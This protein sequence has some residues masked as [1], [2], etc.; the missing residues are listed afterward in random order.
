MTL[1]QL[2]ND[3]TN[4]A[5]TLYNSCVNRDKGHSLFKGGR[6]NAGI[7]KGKLG[8][9]LQK[10]ITTEEATFYA[11]F[12]PVDLPQETN[13]DQPWPWQQRTQSNSRKKTKDWIQILL[14]LDDHATIFVDVIPAMGTWICDIFNYIPR[15]VWS[16]ATQLIARLYRS[17]KQLF[18][19]TYGN[20]QLS[21]EELEEIR[22]QFFFAKIDTSLEDLFDFSIKIRSGTKKT[23]RQIFCHIEESLAHAQYGKH[24]HVHRHSLYLLFHIA[25]LD[26]DWQGK[27]FDAST[28]TYQKHILKI[29]DPSCESVLYTALLEV[30]Y[31]DGH[32]SSL[33]WSTIQGLQNTVPIPAFPML[34]STTPFANWLPES[35]NIIRKKVLNIRALKTNTQLV[36]RFHVTNGMF[37]KAKTNSRT[38]QLYH[39]IQDWMASHQTKAEW[40]EFTYDY[41]AKWLQTFNDPAKSSILQN[42]VKTIEA[43]SPVEQRKKLIENYTLFIGQDDYAIQTNE[44]RKVAFFELW[45][46]LSMPNMFEGSFGTHLIETRIPLIFDRVEGLNQSMLEFV[47]A[48]FHKEVGK[49]E[50]SRL[51]LLLA[52]LVQEQKLGSNDH[53]LSQLIRDGIFGRLFVLE[54]K[55]DDS[56][57]SVAGIT[58]H[59][60]SP[61]AVW[62]MKTSHFKAYRTPLLY[63]II[64]SFL[65]DCHSEAQKFYLFW[66]LSIYEP[67][68]EIYELFAKNLQFPF[69]LLHDTPVKY[70]NIDWVEKCALLQNLS[71][72]QAQ[73]DHDL[74]PNKNKRSVAPIDILQQYGAIWQPFIDNNRSVFLLKNE[75]A[76]NERVWNEM[77]SFWEK[78]TQTDVFDT[79]LQLKDWQEQHGCFTSFLRN[80]QQFLAT[81]FHDASNEPIQSVIQQIDTIC[82]DLER[83]NISDFEEGLRI[84]CEKDPHYLKHRVPF[85][86]NFMYA[87]TVSKLQIVLKKIVHTETKYLKWDEEIVS[88][89]I[90]FDKMAS[91]FAN[92]DGYWNHT[93]QVFENSSIEDLIAK[94]WIDN[95]GY[96]DAWSNNEYLVGLQE[97]EH[98]FEYYPFGLFRAYLSLIEQVVQNPNIL[99]KQYYSLCMAILKRLEDPEIQSKTTELVTFDN[100]KFLTQIDSYCKNFRK[101]GLFTI[102]V[103][104]SESHEST[105]FGDKIRRFGQYHCF[106]PFVASV[107]SLTCLLDFGDS[108]LHLYD[109]NHVA[110]ISSVVLSLTTAFL[111]PYFSKHQDVGLP[112]AQSFL[113]SAPTFVASASFSSMVTLIWTLSAEGPV[114]GI[115]P[116]LLML[117]FTTIIKAAADGAFD[118]DT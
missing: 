38:A 32:Q 82:D 6:F 20:S 64:Q 41:L 80:F 13:K 21:I 81:I 105:K 52:I 25:L 15:D 79:Y 97:Y 72:N 11:A 116:F 44:E 9:V 37:P 31:F 110:G 90:K 30:C 91:Y 1:Q 49:A 17:S 5:Q 3:S 10:N 84:I 65:M 14:D 47:K 53:D 8:G 70:T 75:P 101:Q 59:S 85:A 19:T 56:I 96:S 12:L 89:N 46:L 109:Y 48:Q 51:V 24:S 61:I 76:W 34:T 63:Q 67:D 2:Q 117:F 26:A 112:I 33:N 40:H 35:E 107:F 118:T 87:T 68:D 95:L 114:M 39:D 62:F 100:A 98:V 29:T 28:N 16:M 7:W 73:I 94:S 42:H 57:F 43:L 54:T 83:G 45:Y 50:Y 113:N 78:W 88:P 36:M 93:Q 71:A 23:T 102:A 103:K 58:N 99:G 92:D 27:L 77:V 106:K 86:F 108:L 60:A 111:Y 104:L 74:N 4:L 55:T 22:S 69:H 115:A 18:A 66:K